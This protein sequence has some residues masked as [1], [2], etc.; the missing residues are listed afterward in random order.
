MLAFQPEDQR[1]TILEASE[2][3]EPVIE[4]VLSQMDKVRQKG[5]FIGASPQISGVTNISYPI[6]NSNRQVE[7][8]LTMPFLTLNSDSLHHQVV[9]FE[10]SRLAV[11]DAADNLIHAI[12]GSK[13]E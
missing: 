11:A 8:V 12:G 10:E 1:R 6:F 13:P 7:A 3:P 4:S 9:S 2:T 5:Y